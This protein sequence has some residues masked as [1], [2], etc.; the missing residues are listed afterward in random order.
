MIQSEEKKI[1]AEGKL[2][3]YSEAVSLASKK[4]KKEGK[5]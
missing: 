3:K 1:W 4:L 2:K 5:L